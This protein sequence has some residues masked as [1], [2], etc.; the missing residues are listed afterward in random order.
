MPLIL[1]ADDD[2]RA[3]A[4][5]GLPHVQVKC[6]VSNLP[7]GDGTL[8]SFGFFT[9]AFFPSVAP[10]GFNRFMELISTHFYDDTRVF[11]VEPGFVVQFGISGS[12]GVGSK[13]LGMPLM[14]EPVR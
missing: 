5:E 10:I 12:P 3:L 6:S 13:W 9:L 8:E 4:G 7:T 2:G 14:D 1:L 11:R